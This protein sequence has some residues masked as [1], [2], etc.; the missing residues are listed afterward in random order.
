MCLPS[1]RSFTGEGHVSVNNVR[2]YDVR[3]SITIQGDQ[4]T[5]TV[6]IS[7][8]R[9][10]VATFTDQPLRASSEVIS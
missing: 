5:V 10:L 1:T 4:T 9:R 3:F 7:R 6:V 8:G 2:G